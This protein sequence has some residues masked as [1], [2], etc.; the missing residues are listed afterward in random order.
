MVPSYEATM[1][2]GAGK[3]LLGARIEVGDD[4]MSFMWDGIVVRSSQQMLPL[5]KVWERVGRG[6]L[7]ASQPSGGVGSVPVGWGTGA[8]ASTQ[9]VN[10]P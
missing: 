3:R 1:L 4:C 8:E 2:W 7:C 6:K 10:D 5:C 9:T